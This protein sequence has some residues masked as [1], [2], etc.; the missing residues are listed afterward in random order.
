MGQKDSPSH[1][2]S[3]SVQNKELEVMP[4]GEGSLDLEAEKALR[5][6]V[7]GLLEQEDSKWR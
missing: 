3:Y 2:R 6:E 4:E 5:E 7:N 1:G